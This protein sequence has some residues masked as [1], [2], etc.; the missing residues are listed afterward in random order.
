MAALKDILNR[1]DEI[2]RVAAKHG[3]RNVRLFGSVVRGEAKESSDVDVLV[4]LDEDRSLLDH[5]ALK[6]DL[7]DL[8]GCKVDVVTEGALHKLL[9]DRILQEAVPL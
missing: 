6:Q 9:R 5:V 4:K 3:A 2:L 7:E 1:R 8:L